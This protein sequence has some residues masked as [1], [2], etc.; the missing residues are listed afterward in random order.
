MTLSPA[1]D[2]ILSSLRANVES[3]TIEK[4]GTE[5]GSVYLPNVGSGHSFAGH[6][7][8]LEAAGLYRRAG[9]PCFGEVLRAPKVENKRA[10]VKAAFAALKANRT[11]NNPLHG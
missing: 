10:K 9:D 2:A 5:W 11:F 8:A 7:S 6:L 1:A 4:D 3:T